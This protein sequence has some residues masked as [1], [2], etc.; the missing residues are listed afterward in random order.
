ME[1]PGYDEN[2][3]P[4]ASLGF[5]VA[6]ED[7]KYVPAVVKICGDCIHVSAPG[8]SFPVYARYLWTNYTDVVVYGADGIP[9]AP[10]R[11][12]RRDGFKPLNQ[13]AEIQQNMETGSR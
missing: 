1:R 2:A 11:T 10:F 7:G 8:I 6:G 3:Y 13:N 9:L 4:A 12:D 5:E